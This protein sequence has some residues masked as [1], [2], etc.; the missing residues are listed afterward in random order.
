MKKQEDL[1]KA[2]EK[3][4][5]TMRVNDVKG[6]ID[7]ASR[8]ISVIEAMSEDA[9]EPNNNIRNRLISADVI[10]TDSHLLDE[11]L[12]DIR[13]IIEQVRHDINCGLIEPEA[14]EGEE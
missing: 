12:D 5:S 2:L 13:A 3:V 10:K 7:N 6:M 11:T 1:Y 9:A 8:M 14:E 4:E